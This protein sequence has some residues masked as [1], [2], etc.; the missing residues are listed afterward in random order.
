MRQSVVE[1]GISDKAICSAH[2]ESSAD[3][4]LVAV[5]LQ[6]VRGRE[7]SKKV[8]HQVDPIQTTLQHNPKQFTD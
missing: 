6:L 1:I 4:L 5:W 3:E 7:V 8:I 2:R